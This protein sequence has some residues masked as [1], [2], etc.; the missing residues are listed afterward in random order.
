MFDTITKAG[1]WVLF[2]ALPFLVG[3]AVL[4]F[5]VWLVLHLIYRRRL[6]DWARWV[7]RVYPQVQRLGRSW[8]LY[9][10]P[11][12]ASALCYVVWLLNL[13]EVC[14]QNRLPRLRWEAGPYESWA[15]YE[16]RMRLR[17]AMLQAHLPPDSRLRLMPL[18]TLLNE[19]YFAATLGVEKCTV[20]QEYEAE[21]KIRHAAWQAS[22]DVRDSDKHG[23]L[24][25]GATGD[26]WLQRIDDLRENLPVDSPARTKSI[27][28]LTLEYNDP[29]WQERE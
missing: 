15:E 29:R 26:Y 20:W 1:Q 7:D 22:Q 28:E 6:W 4:V 17:F 27:K 14:R 23:A 13:Q 19:V 11:E 10:P 24:F 5:L 18:K 3:I 8:A 9:A 2:T 16:A 12:M 25:A 21:K